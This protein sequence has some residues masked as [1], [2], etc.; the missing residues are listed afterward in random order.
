MPAPHNVLRCLLV[1]PT[2]SGRHAVYHRDLSGPGIATGHFILGS[3]GY[4]TWLIWHLSREWHKET[5]CVLPLTTI[6]RLM[7]ETGSG[8]TAVC[9]NLPQIAST[10]M[11]KYQPVLEPRNQERSLPCGERPPFLHF[12]NPSFATIP[13]RWSSSGFD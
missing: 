9:V 11:M 1:Y 3:Q 13:C 4:S 6:D 5:I 2:A 8:K 12:R 10:L 7:G